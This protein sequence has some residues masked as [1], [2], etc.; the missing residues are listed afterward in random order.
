MTYVSS[1]YK[2]DAFNCPSCGAYAKQH[3]E[4]ETESV[5]ST[6]I[7][8][9]MVAICDRCKKFSI[10]VDEK[11]VYPLVDG[12]P[13]P[14][15]EMPDDIKGEYEEARS[16]VSRSP[17]S[18]AALLRLAIEKLTNLLL[19][20]E[21][22]KDLNENIATL[23]QKGLPVKIQKALDYLR[24]IGNNAVHPLGKIDLQDNKQVANSLFDILNMIVDDMISEPSRIDK[25]YDT[26]PEKDKSNIEKRDSKDPRK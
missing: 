3:W 16:I 21:K 11:M 24:V 23:V 4:K 22:G 8:I 7:N 26:L 15:P 13:N 6:F 17:R 2:K 10:W 9:G 18:A 19:G 5:G 12:T 25:V 20:N 1:E 14:H